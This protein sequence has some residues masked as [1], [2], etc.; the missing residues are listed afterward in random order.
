MD[1]SSMAYFAQQLNTRP[2][3]QSSLAIA[4]VKSL[5]L[6]LKKANTFGGIKPLIHSL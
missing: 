1:E 6:V 3:A 5:L 4:Y 2:R